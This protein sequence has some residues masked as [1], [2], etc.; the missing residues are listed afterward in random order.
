M[1]D[2]VAARIAGETTIGVVATVIIGAGVLAALI[3]QVTM[4]VVAVVDGVAVVIG[5]RI[6]TV[7]LVIAAASVPLRCPHT[8]VI[9]RAGIG[10]IARI[11][12]GIGA[13]IRITGVADRAG[14]C[15]VAGVAASGAALK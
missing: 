7:A 4:V 13:S 9:A 11:P 6:V 2:I 5:A 3:S 10:L 12:R 15:G 1:A 14:I 8:I